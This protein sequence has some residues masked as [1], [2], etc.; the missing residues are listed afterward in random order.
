MPQKSTAY[1][2]RREDG[3]YNVYM[4]RFAG[5]EVPRDRQYPVYTW[6]DITRAQTVCDAL[7]NGLVMRIE[8]AASA[9]KRE[10]RA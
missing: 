3:R 7:N 4:T 6:P 5:A 1:Q 9:A 2:M 8:A 10:R